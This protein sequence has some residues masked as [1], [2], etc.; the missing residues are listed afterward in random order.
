M[1]GLQ[2]RQQFQRGLLIPRRRQR[3]HLQQ[4]VRRPR[5]RAHHHHRTLAP[6]LLHN[7]A[8]SLNRARIFH[9]RSAKLHNNHD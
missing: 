5:Q 2:I 1:P 9:R 7:R 4:P 8:Q 3:R 6:P